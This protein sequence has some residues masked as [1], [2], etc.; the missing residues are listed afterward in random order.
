MR[1][2]SCPTAWIARFWKL[3][4]PRIEPNTTIDKTNWWNDSS[5]YSSILIDWCLVQLPSVRL[6]LAINGCGHRNPQPIILLRESKLEVSIE[7]FPSMEQLFEIFQKRGR[8][9]C[10]SQSRWRIPGEHLLL[11]Q[12]GRV[13]MGSQD[14]SGKH[15]SG[16]GSS[17]HFS[18]LL[19]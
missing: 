17:A 5:W 15:W 7:L 6:P 16:L 14:C 3:N 11:N 8:K 13:H 10:R 18:W 9:D 1:G 12:L 4:R 2:S 19:A